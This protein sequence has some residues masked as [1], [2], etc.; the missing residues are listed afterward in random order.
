MLISFIYGGV[1]KSIKNHGEIGLFVKIQSSTNTVQVDLFIFIDHAHAQFIHMYVLVYIIYPLSHK[2][3]K[4]RF[5]VA[6]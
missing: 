6:I 2:F 4:F 5:Y 1:I 3:F